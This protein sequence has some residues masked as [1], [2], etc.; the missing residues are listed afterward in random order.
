MD[1]FLLSHNFERCKSDKNMY[2]QKYEGNFLIIVLYVYDLIITGST[3][4]SIIFIKIAL[5]E[6]FEM[7]DLDPLR[8]FLELE[9]TQDFDGIIVKQYKYVLYLLITFNMADFKAAPFPFL[10]GISVEE[11]NTTPHVDSTLY[12]Q[13]IRNLHY[14]THSRPGICYCE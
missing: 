12:R 1:Y 11:G 2:L 5:H 6:A 8:Q 9:I 7:S 14:L 13:L 4:A 10:L 3:L